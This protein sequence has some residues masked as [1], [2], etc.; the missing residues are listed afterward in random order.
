MIPAPIEEVDVDALRALI[1]NGVREGKTIEYKHAMP[2]TAE[3]N[4][5]PF[6]ATVSSFANT[7]GGDLLLG[8]DAVDGVPTALPGI[9]IDNLDQETLRLEQ[10]LRNGL[11]PRLPHIDIRAISVSDDNYVL[12]IRVPKSWIAPH[13]VKRNS[14]FYAR[15]SAGRYELDVGELRTAFTMSE[16]I[17]E[18]IRNFRADR[19]AKIHSRETPVTLI[20]GG[21][22]VVH[23][24]PLGAFMATTAIDIAA[25]EAITLHLLPMGDSGWSSRVNLDGLVTFTEDHERLSRAYSQIFRTGAV[26]SVAVLVTHDDHMPLL[27]I[28]YEQDVMSFLRR[29]LSLTAE[30]DIEPPYYV[31]LSFVGV[32]GCRFGVRTGMFRPGDVLPLR[33]NMLILP[34]VVIDDRDA[35]PHRVLRPVFDM[36]WNAFGLIRSF[37]YDDQGNWVEQ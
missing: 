10:V 3:S 11:E 17:A 18:R 33:E 31:F 28:A 9:E 14:K 32:Q 29:Y 7:A 20:P 12:V 36:V 19:I 5:V 23:V 37:N 24:F 1:T 16:T 15:N 21:C 8:I 4:V 30:F 25:H 35:Q 22:M 6:L 2:G 34:E 26:E 27:S 13:R